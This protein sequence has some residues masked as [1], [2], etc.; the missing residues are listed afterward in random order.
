MSSRIHSSIRPAASSA[1]LLLVLGCSGKS[2]GSTIIEPPEPPT[3][4]SPAPTPADPV[5]PALP[6]LFAEFVDRNVFPVA[7]HTRPRHLDAIRTVGF[8]DLDGDG[9]LDAI[10]P[11]F[12]WIQTAPARFVDEST[13]RLFPRAEPN[14]LNYAMKRPVVLDIDG[15]GDLD[16]FTG[17]HDPSRL[18]VNNGAGVFTDQTETLAPP[19][20]AETTPVAAADVDVDGDLD[21][22][23]ARDFVPAELL[24]ND[25]FGRFVSAAGL[26]T[27]E[28]FQEG[29]IVAVLPFAANGDSAPDLYVARESFYA[30]DPPIFFEGRNDIFVNDGTGSFTPILNVSGPDRPVAADFDGTLAQPV[31]SSLAWNGVG[32]GDFDANGHVDIVIGNRVVFANPGG[33]W[34]GNPSI[35]S[36]AS[37][38]SAATRRPPPRATAS[39]WRTTARACS[40]M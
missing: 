15:D 5:E 11:D 22:I 19:L 9:D 1:L 3:T 37:C 20:P 35:I 34:D 4:P 14:V 18:Y 24:L 29:R 32:F 16:F 12:V 38:S 27:T 39:S 8:A 21:V 26:P 28:A 30:E 2:G 6:R 7:D 10:G 17:A 40:P 23:A 13:V 36:L 33:G 31:L 25:G